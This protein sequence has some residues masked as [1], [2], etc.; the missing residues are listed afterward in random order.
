MRGSRKKAS[1]CTQ[2]QKGKKV[3]MKVRHCIEIEFEE[4]IDDSKIGGE[5]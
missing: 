1:L 4:I 5:S 2:Q 3:K